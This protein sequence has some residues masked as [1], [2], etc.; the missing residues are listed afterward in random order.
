MSSS[1]HATL[2]VRA[3]ASLVPGK[4]LTSNAAECALAHGLPSKIVDRA[5]EVRYVQLTGRCHLQHAMSSLTRSELI[6][7][8]EIAR[9]HDRP[10]SAQDVK[11]LKQAEELA[12]MFLAWDIDETTQDVLDVL[13]NMIEV[14]YGGDDDE[15]EEKAEVHDGVGNEPVA[16]VEEIDDDSEGHGNV[17]GSRQAQD[18][19]EWQD[20]QQRHQD[21][22]SDEH[23]GKLFIDASGS[24]SSQ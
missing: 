4:R 12:K 10:L 17:G 20:D 8:F 7:K 5:R 21:Q 11:E 9:I 22:G 1:I 16:K 14:V 13:R 6:S 19:G 24:D 2:R 23:Y 3:D 18:G 15:E